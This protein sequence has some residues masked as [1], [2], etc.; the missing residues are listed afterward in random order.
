VKSRWIT[1]ALVVG[2]SFV[3]LGWVGVRIYQQAPPVPKEIATADGQFVVAGS[4]I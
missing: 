2:L 4:D 3:V 1:F